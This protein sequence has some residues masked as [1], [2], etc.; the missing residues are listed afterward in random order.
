MDLGFLATDLEVRETFCGLLMRRVT[1]SGIL[2]AV[3]GSRHLPVLR[4]RDLAFN[5][6]SAGGAMELGTEMDSH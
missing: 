3:D 1:R 4:Y 6:A 2:A 5:N